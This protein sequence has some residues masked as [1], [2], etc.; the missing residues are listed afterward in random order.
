MG[1]TILGTPLYMSP[2]VVERLDNKTNKKYNTSADLW[3]LGVITYELLTGTTPFVG[4]KYEE[5]FQN[6]EKGS[7]K[8]P[9]KLK[10]SIEIISFIN[11]LLQYYPEKRYDW[12]QIKQ[13]PFLTK[14]VEDFN[15]VDLELYSDGEKKEV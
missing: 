2:D 8:L 5:V 6:I 11:G 15:F 9:K 13:H 4:A 10:P 1:S 14:N 3:S 7:Y 12:E